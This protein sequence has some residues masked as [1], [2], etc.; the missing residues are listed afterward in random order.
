[1][2]IID[3]SQVLIG[4]IHLH[5]RDIERLRGDGDKTGLIKHLFLNTILSYKK[6][7]S[8][9]YGEVVLAADSKNYWRRSVFPSY[10]GHRAR[11]REASDF[12]WTA[13]FE[14]MNEFKND[15]RENFNFKLIEVDGAEADDVI[16]VLCEWT[17]DNQLVQDGLFDSEPQPV[18]IVS[19]DGDFISLQKFSNVKQLSPITTKLVKPKV[20]PQKH[21]IEKIVRGDAGDNIPNVFTPDDW[22]IKRIKGEDTIRANSVKDSRLQEFLLLGYDACKNDT[23]RSHYERNRLLIDF[24]CIPVQLKDTIV[25]TYENYVSSGSKN[26]IMNYLIKNRL[27]NLIQELGEF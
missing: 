14:I 12:D 27:K 7:Y 22:S 17:Q 5:A 13:I 23:E 6:K 10:K 16:A 3:L 26:K 2:I 4:T 21:L 8:D 9:T 25:S 20:S 15:I 18:L 1:M 19:S 11:M 24:E